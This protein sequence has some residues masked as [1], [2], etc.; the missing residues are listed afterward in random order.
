MRVGAFIAAFVVPFAVAALPLLTLLVNPFASSP[1]D[2]RLAV[3]DVPITSPILESAESAPMA[4]GSSHASASLDC[5]GTS[6]VA[7]EG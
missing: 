3:R 2:G 4:Y 5:D 1:D 6:I 7:I